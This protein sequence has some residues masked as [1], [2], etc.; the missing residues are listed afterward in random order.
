MSG[1]APQTKKTSFFILRNVFVSMV[2]GLTFF[3]Q[4]VSWQIFQIP[5]AH[6]DVNTFGQ[7]GTDGLFEDCTDDDTVREKQWAVDGG[8]GIRECIDE[9]ARTVT[10]SL[11]EKWNT[12]KPKFRSFFD[13]YVDTAIPEV[14]RNKSYYVTTPAGHGQ[15]V[16]SVNAFL[17]E[18]DDGLDGLDHIGKILDYLAFPDLDRVP[19]YSPQQFLCNLL[20]ALKGGVLVS[21]EYGEDGLGGNGSREYRDWILYGPDEDGNGPGPSE[22]DTKVLSDDE[23][24]YLIRGLPTALTYFIADLLSDTSV[25]LDTLMEENRSHATPIRTIASQ[26]KEF[27]LNPPTDGET[28]AIVTKHGVDY[29]DLGI[30]MEQHAEIFGTP[31]GDGPIE[32]L[33]KKCQSDF[34][35]EAASTYAQRISQCYS[36]NLSRGDPSV[37]MTERAREFMRDIIIPATQAFASAISRAPPEQQQRVKDFMS[38][39]DYT[40]LAEG[41]DPLALQRQEYNMKDY[42]DEII[43]AGYGNTCSSCSWQYDTDL[44]SGVHPVTTDNAPTKDILRH[45]VEVNNRLIADDMFTKYLDPPLP[46]GAS[47]SSATATPV[48]E[49]GSEDSVVSAMRTLGQSR[50]GRVQIESKRNALQ[51]MND[52]IR[53]TASGDTLLHLWYTLAVSDHDPNYNNGIAHTTSGDLSL[54]AE[55]EPGGW[56]DQVMADTF[57]SRIANACSPNYWNDNVGRDGLT[58]FKTCLEH[59]KEY[60]DKSDTNRT[61]KI[62]ATLLLNLGALDVTLSS[63]APTLSMRRSGPV[64]EGISDMIAIIQSCLDTPSCEGVDDEELGHIGSEVAGIDDSG[65]ATASTVAS[66]LLN[67]VLSLLNVLLSLIVKFLLWLTALVMDMFHAVLNYSGFTTE[68]FVIAM[69]RAIRDFVNLFFILALLIISIANIVQYQINT[70]A[71]KTILPKFI[72]IVLAVNFSRLFTGLV[73]D[74]AIVVEA[75]VYQIGGMGPHGAGGTAACSNQSATSGALTFGIPDRIK[76]GSVLCRLARGLKFEELQAYGT[77]GQGDDVDQVDLFLVNMVLIIMLIMMLFG[78]L[79][80]AVTFTIRIF[81]LWALV[82]VSPLYVISKLF[83]FTNS[84]GSQW[85]GKFFKY[86]TMQVGVAFFLTLA[87]MS[88]GLIGARIFGD[89]SAVATGS[90]GNLHPAGFTTF[91]DYLQLG[92]LMAMIYAATFTAAK[93]DY[94]TGLIDKISAY[95]RNPLGTARRGAGLALG[96]TGGVGR[97]LQAV[98]GTGLLARGVRILGGGIAA[99]SNIYEGGKAI[100]G[101]L[102]RGAEERKAEFGTKAAAVMARGLPGAARM[103]DRFRGQIEATQRKL[104]EEREVDMRLRLSIPE[105]QSR[106]DKAGAARNTTEYLA[107]ATALSKMGALDLKKET[108]AEI[109]GEDGKKRAETVR[110]R[111]I[112][113]ESDRTKNPEQAK[114]LVDELDRTNQGAYDSNQKQAYDFAKRTDDKKEIRA[115]LDEYVK[116][117][118]KAGAMGILQAGFEGR[119]SGGAGEAMEYWESLQGKDSPIHITRDDRRRFG[120]DLSKDGVAAVGVM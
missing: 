9:D 68:G 49:N 53:R 30:F 88:A 56:W 8:S 84:I 58:P 93:S 22:C 60:V 105:I 75:G 11:A 46:A 1:P 92:F 34:S 32:A 80:L 118:N 16:R 66:A 42:L 81:I 26:L 65:G 104:V 4:T 31:E 35:G 115:K 40:N 3:S 12:V 23:R 61:H 96:L 25:N 113:N 119:L 78:F 2:F 54:S 15:V 111:L 116:R 21:T 69:W 41:Y 97:R 55:A 48:T 71:I 98:K 7:F 45:L 70:Y 51:Q 106:M 91:A 13:P 52:Y 110:D 37:P 103:R 43:F 79:A 59:E 74:A 67:A 38:N 87:A 108:G 28:N 102:K 112:K 73:I 29:L 5:T 114:N 50:V 47:T 39:S 44:L 36:D 10:T 120:R 89:V 24:P 83:P 64:V 94:G 18:E 99:P 77:L 57:L 117:G 19:T 85:E 82:I 6:A 95:G 101:E 76:E 107:A 27:V 86:A 14:L 109:I 100:A 90:V 33:F 17:A 72:L 20:N 62:H 63:S